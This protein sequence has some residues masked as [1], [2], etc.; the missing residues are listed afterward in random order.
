MDKRAITKWPVPMFTLK[1]KDNVK[2]RIIQEANSIILRKP[3]NHK[4]LPKGV[5]WLKNLKI[6]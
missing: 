5:K 1:R 2:G 6:L 4:G 3:D